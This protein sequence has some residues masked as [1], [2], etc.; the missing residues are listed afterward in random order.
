MTEL[1]V[2]FIVA[3][4]VVGPDRLPTYAKKLGAALAQF[5]KYSEDATKDI[6]ESIVEP[7][8]EAQRPLK[9]AVEPLEELDKTVRS[10]VKEVEDSFKN[11]GKPKKKTAANKETAEETV[12]TETPEPE[13]T[14]TAEPSEEVTPEAAASAETPEPE[15]TETAEPS[16]EVKTEATETTETENTEPAETNTETLPE[17]DTTQE[18]ELSIT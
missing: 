18:E 14:E 9:E 5:K 6:K 11:I 2:I 17:T 12:S 8:E 4:F 16:E 3:L 7:L 1:I 13:E 15:E 10:N